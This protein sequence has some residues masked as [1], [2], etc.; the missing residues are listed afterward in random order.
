MTGNTHLEETPREGL[1][2]QEL[3]TYE[4]KNGVL[5]K[6]I[7][8][9]RFGEPTSNDYIDSCSSEPILVFKK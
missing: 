6:M 1:L 8:E 9:R 7:T 3:I 5:Y 2:K 4:V